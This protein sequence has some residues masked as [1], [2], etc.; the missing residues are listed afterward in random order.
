MPFS[1]LSQGQSAALMFVVAALSSPKTPQKLK[2]II[3]GGDW[4]TVETILS[5]GTPSNVATPSE[6]DFRFVGAM[7]PGV[8]NVN[9]V[10]ALMDLK[11]SA[12]AKQKFQQAL[13]SHCWDRV[14]N[15]LR[16]ALSAT[17]MQFTGADLH[18]AY[19]PNDR[20]PCQGPSDLEK[21]IGEFVKDGKLVGNFFSKSLPDFFEHDFANFFTGSI[22]DFFKGDFSRFFTSIGDQIK[23]GFVSLGDKLEDVG[24]TIVEK[25]NPSNW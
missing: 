4:H 9:F 17:G 7:S 2:D 16:D 23:D 15:A 3:N 24:K 10:L 25:L 18:Q 11:S 22:P 8:R 20:A 1:K 21:V 12:D 6:D 19:A 13:D 14:A 5:M